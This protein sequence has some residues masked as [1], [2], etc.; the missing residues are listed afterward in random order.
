M[1][2]EKMKQ[3]RSSSGLA[4]RDESVFYDWLKKYKAEDC[5]CKIIVAVG[6]SARLGSPPEVFT[7]NGNDSII[8][9]GV[10]IKRQTDQ[11]LLTICTK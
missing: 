10:I 5:K 2:G 6:E 9:K 8:R 11:L 7:T 1:D 4:S 3:K